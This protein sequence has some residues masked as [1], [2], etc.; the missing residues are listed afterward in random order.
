[1]FTRMALYVV[2]HQDDWQLFMDPGISADILDATCKT[3]IIHTTA[4]DAGE[5]RKFWQAREQGAI[6]SLLFRHCRHSHANVSRKYVGIG[7]KKVYLA[8]AANCGLYFLRLPDGGMHGQGF[9]AYGFGSLGR[10]RLQRIDC[11]TSVD[12]LNTFRSTAEISRL[13]DGIFTRELRRNPVADR[14]RVTLSFP[15]YDHARNPDDHNDHFQTALLLRDTDAYGPA[16]KYAFVHYDIQH[17]A[18]DLEGT[19]LFWKVGMFCAYHQAVL[20]AHG[21]STI[22]ESPQYYRWCT[23]N[24]IRR[25]VV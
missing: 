6:N 2:A 7:G 9:A 24:S 12:Q 19:D 4:G 13:L 3:I 16:K 1:M 25:E 20:D 22:D 23:K 15:E 5:D 8:E 10:L 14:S 18:A 17:S 21:Y 11:L